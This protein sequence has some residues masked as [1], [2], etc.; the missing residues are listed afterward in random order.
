MAN[1]TVA[2]RAN[3][4]GASILDTGV[5]SMSAVLD[6]ATV[7]GTRATVDTFDIMQIPVGA[8]VLGGATEI[9]T[10]DTSAT[11]TLVVAA[12]GVVTRASATGLDAAVGT[13]TVG[14]TVGRATTTD[15]VVTTGVQ[16]VDTLKV[17]VTVFYTY[18]AQNFGTLVGFG[19]GA[20][21]TDPGITMVAE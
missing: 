9:L 19:S 8:L 4:T 15:V 20:S 1:F 5:L 3:A 14:N 6:V 17:R 13:T 12:G 2:K 16:A 11:A 18:P 7:P 10:A 21:E